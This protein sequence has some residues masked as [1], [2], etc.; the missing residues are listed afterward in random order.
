MA[1]FDRE[2]RQQEGPWSHPVFGY[3]AAFLL[4]IA[5]VTV[6]AMLVQGFPSFRFQGYCQLN[7]FS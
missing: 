6:M 4:P 3:L 7:F 2:Q 1:A 5:A